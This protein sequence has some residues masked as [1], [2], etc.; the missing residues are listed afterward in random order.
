MASSITITAL[1]DHSPIYPIS[2]LQNSEQFK[3]KSLMAPSTARVSDF[4]TKPPM[5]R[6]TYYQYELEHI[7]FP[8]ANEFVIAEDE[9]EDSPKNS[10][11]YRH[12][13][14]K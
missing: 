2:H 3:K 1:D 4:T 12:Y 14:T 11:K 9:M 8:I 10:S 6:S 7:N 5:K 13:R